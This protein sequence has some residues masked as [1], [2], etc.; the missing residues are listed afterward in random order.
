MSDG[1]NVN[2]ND[3]K[4]AFAAVRDHAK[5]HRV[6]LCDY[7]IALFV[8]EVAEFIAAKNGEIRW[9]RKIIDQREDT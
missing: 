6:D 5:R 1:W 3:F 8:E 4:M 7:D 9:L 2:D